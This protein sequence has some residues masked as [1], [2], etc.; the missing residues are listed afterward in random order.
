MTAADCQKSL[1]R[2]RVCRNTCVSYYVYVLLVGT[3]NLLSLS[4]SISGEVQSFV[5]PLSVHICDRDGTY[6]FQL[7]ALTI[8]Y[9]LF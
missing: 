5:Q 7:F 4:L 6:K 1:D 8:A 3:Y 9:F 2:A